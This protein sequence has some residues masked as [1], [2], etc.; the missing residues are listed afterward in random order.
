MPLKHRSLAVDITSHPLS[1][2]CPISSSGTFTEEKMLVGSEN[3]H[4]KYVGFDSSTR[5][6]Y[7]ESQNPEGDAEL[8]YNEVSTE[9]KCTSPSTGNQLIH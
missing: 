8:Q 6:V 1:S 5:I 7:D 3:A 2:S 9:S 4:L